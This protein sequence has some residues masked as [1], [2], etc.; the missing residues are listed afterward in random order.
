MPRSVANAPAFWHTPVLPQVTH[1]CTSP[2]RLFTPAPCHLSAQTEQ[3]GA[4]SAGGARTGSPVVVGRALGVLEIEDAVR[5]QRRVVRHAV[6]ERDAD[7]VA[8][9]RADHRAQQPQVLVLRAA[10]LRAP[11]RDASRIADQSAR[12]ELLHD[13]RWR[14]AAG[15][16]HACMHACMSAAA[17]GNKTPHPPTQHKTLRARLSKH[18]E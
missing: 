3:H 14:V 2:S 13:L 17:L 8:D 18:A 4:G 11:G 10:V 5:V 7:G 6:L 12:R 15:A 9:R 1:Y 16:A